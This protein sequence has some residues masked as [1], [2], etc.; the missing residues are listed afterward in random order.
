MGTHT[1]YTKI[2]FG[3]KILL[4]KQFWFS[5]RDEKNPLENNI[6]ERKYFVVTIFNNQNWCQHDP[7]N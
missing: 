4:K 3:P 6:K 7:F 1:C 2:Y 5:M